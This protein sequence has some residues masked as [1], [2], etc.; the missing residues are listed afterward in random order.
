MEENATLLVAGA[1]FQFKNM[2]DTEY[3]EFKTGI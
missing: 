1:E 3:S 2:H